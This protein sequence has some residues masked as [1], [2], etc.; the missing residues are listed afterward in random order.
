MQ[1]IICPLYPYRAALKK[2]KEKEMHPDWRGRSRSVFIPILHVHLCSKSDGIYKK[3]TRT[4]K[5]VG[6]FSKT[7]GYKV[8]I[9]K[10]IVIFYTNNQQSEMEINKTTHSQ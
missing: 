8:N 5:S 10:S 7:T 1:F 3:A 9:Q 2:K 4:N 6:E